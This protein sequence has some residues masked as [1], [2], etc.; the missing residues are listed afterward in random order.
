[1]AAGHLQCLA[2]TPSRDSERSQTLPIIKT[3]GAEPEAQH[4]I[5]DEQGSRTS[6]RRDD[7]RESSRH[8][9]KEDADEDA[10]RHS[11]A[12][13]DPPPGGDPEDPPGGGGG[14]GGSGPSRRPTNDPNDDKNNTR[15]FF[16][17]MYSFWGL[18]NTS[19]L[20]WRSSSAPS[21]TRS[22]LTKISKC[23]EDSH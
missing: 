16:N 5:H 3:M 2:V 23:S 13:T 1:M 10:D 14:G 7:E 20:F 21:G 22:T 8:D 6:E 19:L 9:N 11:Q 17:L 4:S 12:S 18:I 15:Q